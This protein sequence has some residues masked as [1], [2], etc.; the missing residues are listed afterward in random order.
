MKN[1]LIVGFQSTAAH[2]FLG[3]CFG[4]FFKIYH[5]LYPL[6]IFLFVITGLLT[7]GF[8]SKYFRNC[9]SGLFEKFNITYYGLIVFAISGIY[10]ILMK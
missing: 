2:I 6:L 8:I 10:I 4:G 9:S 5:N 3:I 1:K 7:V